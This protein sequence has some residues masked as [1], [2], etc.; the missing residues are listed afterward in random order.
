M[1]S[2][3]QPD[4][5]HAI[6]VDA[7]T[8]ELSLDEVIQ[9][10][11]SP[12]QD[13]APNYNGVFVGTLKSIDGNGAAIV[14]VAGLGELPARATVPL[15]GDDFGKD[16]AVMFEQGNPAKPILIGV[17]QNAMAPSQELRATVDDERLTLTAD[18][19]IVLKCGKASIT[20]T[21]AG[22]IL[23]RGAYLSSRSS[24]VNRIKGGSVQIN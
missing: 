19:E 3:R 2:D 11:E 17:M 9:N 21:R 24:G 13:A 4:A 8:D 20:L 22:K 7:A 23:L 10:S 5:D 16:V 6:E 18:R 14:E 1:N 12:G 15:S